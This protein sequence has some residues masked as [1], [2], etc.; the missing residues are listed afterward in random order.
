MSVCEGGGWRESCF[1]DYIDILLGICMSEDLLPG[2]EKRVPI[3][4]DIWLRPLWVRK[5]R[6]G[7]HIIKAEH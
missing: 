5:V 1:S 6:S 7:L 3:T 4:P 2:L